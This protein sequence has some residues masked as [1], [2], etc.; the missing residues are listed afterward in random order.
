M[1]VLG[2]VLV[3]GN[4]EE[5]QARFRKALA[6]N[7]GD[8]SRIKMKGVEALAA[9]EAALSPED[10]AYLESAK[11]LIQLPEFNALVVHGGILS[12]M[13]DLNAIDKG[14]AS[15]MLRVRHVTGKD[16]T[17]LTVEL[18]FPF[19]VT[20]DLDALA[21]GH[22]TNV[23]V[24]KKVVRPAGAFISL[25]E[26][27]PDDPFWAEDYDGRFG[28]VYFGHEPYVEAQAPR[29]FPHATG[30][31]LGCVFGGHLAAVVLEEGKTPF[32]HMVPASGKFAAGFWE[33]D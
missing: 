3:M 2:A 27:G 19:E 21:D 24:V 18:D 31:D 1:R 5:Q 10:I 7:K 32:A 16:Q 8:A 15:K 25:G 17:K 9:L 12:S 20:D 13:K 28:R 26:E 14:D 11:P 22:F 4:H 30:L 33:E 6:A 23:S 29:V